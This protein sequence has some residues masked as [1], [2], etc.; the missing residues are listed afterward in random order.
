MSQ[1]NKYMLGQHLT[2]KDID[3]IFSDLSDIDP[4]EPDKKNNEKK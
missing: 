2:A 3:F 4:G 1:T